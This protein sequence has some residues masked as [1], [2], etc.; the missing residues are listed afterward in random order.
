MI[1]PGVVVE[2]DTDRVGSLVTVGSQLGGLDWGRREVMLGGNL[3]ENLLL[4]GSFCA[5]NPKNGFGISSHRPIGSRRNRSAGACFCKRIPVVAS[6]HTPPLTFH[7]HSH[8]REELARR[9]NG[10]GDGD[11]SKHPPLLPS[12][13]AVGHREAAWRPYER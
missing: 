3:S 5:N 6:Y 9:G 7:P 10:G 13:H 8:G 2:C 12:C 4:R 1:A 11:A